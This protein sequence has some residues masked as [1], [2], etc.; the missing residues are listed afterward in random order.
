MSKHPPKQKLYC[1]V[2][3][4]GQDT[5]SPTFVVVAVV[6][7]QDQEKLRLGLMQVEQEARTDGFKWHKS[8]WSRRLQYLNLV[9]ER[10]LGSG[11]VFFGSYP[12]SVMTLETR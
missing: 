9:L 12:K 5:A 10:G 11:E 7:S 2:D 3:E 4:A 6:S 8:Q 1:Y